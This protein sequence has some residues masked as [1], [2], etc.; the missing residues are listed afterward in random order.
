MSNSWYPKGLEHFTSAGIN[1]G[2]DDIRACLVTADYVPVAANEFLS[3]ISGVTGAILSRS[4]SFTGKTNTGG[5]LNCDNFTFPL[6]ANGFVGKWMVVFKWTGSDATSP[7]I[8]VDDTG[9]NFPVTTDGGNITFQVSTG[10]NKLGAI[11]GP[12]VS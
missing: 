10:P 1:W 4:P 2:S 11:G 3:S 7:L 12:V 8:L 6:V 5:V 9:N